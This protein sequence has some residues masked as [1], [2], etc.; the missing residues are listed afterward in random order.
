MSRQKP[1][2]YYD[3]FKKQQSKVRLKNKMHFQARNL[4]RI[5]TKLL[6]ATLSFYQLIIE[7]FRWLFLNI[8]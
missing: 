6:S 7:N 3:D 2:N 1:R 5:S 8:I 4:R